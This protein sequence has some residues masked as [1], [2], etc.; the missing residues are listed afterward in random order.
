MDNRYKLMQSR[1]SPLNVS[2][3]SRH[4]MARRLSLTTERPLQLIPGSLITACRL[5]LT[6]ALTLPL[7]PGSLITACQLSLTT[8]RPLHL[9]PGSLITACQLHLTTALTLP[10]IPGS[11]FSLMTD[12]TNRLNK[13]SRQLITDMPANRAINPNYKFRAL[14]RPKH[15][16]ILAKH[17]RLSRPY[18][19][20]K[21]L[22]STIM[23]RTTHPTTK[24]NI[25]ACRH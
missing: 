23:T 12:Q 14:I 2:I 24:K 18:N 11:Q 1:Q 22:I 15:S 4:T 5:H 10:L 20:R 25:V 9:T 21:M 13:V 8:E 7:I 3:L 6:T 19:S 17:Q 16:R